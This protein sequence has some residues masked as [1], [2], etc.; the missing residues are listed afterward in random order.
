MAIAVHCNFRPLDVAPVV[1]G[2]N[3]EARSASPAKF[4]RNLTKCCRIINDSKHFPGT[5][6]GRPKFLRDEPPSYTKFW[7]NLVEPVLE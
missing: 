6:S 4:Q 1:L 3:Y 7:E 2:F 5:F